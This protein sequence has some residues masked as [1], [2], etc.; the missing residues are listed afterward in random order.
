[1]T[2]FA[3]EFGL[4]SLSLYSLNIKILVSSFH[5]VEKFKCILHRFPNHKIK[6]YWI[7]VNY[8][9]TFKINTLLKGF[10][11]FMNAFLCTKWMTYDYTG[12]KVASVPRELE[13]QKIVSCHTGAGN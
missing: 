1:M 13:L 5:Y 8:W 12:Q 9:S 7:G 2:Y 4:N 3:N 10:L 11:L 6:N